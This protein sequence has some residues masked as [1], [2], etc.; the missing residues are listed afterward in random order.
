MKKAGILAGIL[1]AALL[2]A[3][4]AWA[5]K[6]VLIT[7]D[8]SVSMFTTNTLEK[9]DR[10]AEAFLSVGE[11]K[12]LA[13]MV[14]D[15]L[16]NGDPLLQDR[17][18]QMRKGLFVKPYMSTASQFPPPYWQAGDR[19]ILAAYDSALAVRADE[20][21]LQSPGQVRDIIMEHSP[22]PRGLDDSQ[23]IVLDPNSVV[24]QAFVRAFPGK[25]SLH[26]LA[27]AQAWKLYA[28]KR[29]EGEKLAQVIWISV[30]DE[31]HDTTRSQD[32]HIRSARAAEATANIQERF[33]G[34]YDHHT[35][36]RA[37]VGERIFLT[38]HSIGPRW[39]VLEREKMIMDLLEQRRLQ[40]E[41]LKTSANL[42]GHTQGVE[43]QLNALKQT[44]EE[45]R[46]RSQE[47][48]AEIQ[49]KLEEMNQEIRRLDLMGGRAALAEQM[50]ALKGKIELVRNEIEQKNNLPT[51]EIRLTRLE[52][53][54]KALADEVE[55]QSA[56][57]ENELGFIRGRI[58][59]LDG[60]AN[61]L[62]EENRRTE[63]APAYPENL[64]NIRIGQQVHEQKDI[65]LALN[66]AK[67]EPGGEQLFNRQIT[68]VPVA[69]TSRDFYFDSIF[70]EFLDNKGA[71]LPGITATVPENA[72]IVAG[73]PLVLSMPENENFD[74]AGK[75]RL[76]VEYFVTAPQIAGP[77][78]GRSQEW[79][80]DVKHQKPGLS[81]L[82][83]V[84]L[85][86]LAALALVLWLV[87]SQ[88]GRSAAEDDD[89]IIRDM[90][91]EGGFDEGKAA[92]AGVAGA[93]AAASQL[94]IT[95]KGRKEEYF[96]SEG[97]SLVFDQEDD[98][99]GGAIL[100]D[101]QCPGQRL[102]FKNSQLVLK[103]DSLGLP[104]TLELEQRDG[105]RIKLKIKKI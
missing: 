99:F 79:V 88:R 104:K 76:R 29:D 56:L 47:E 32:E 68:L 55:K 69:F 42:Q 70:M 15:L 46:T 96:L 43:E 75:A 8:I 82:L 28:D 25:A 51:F 49:N 65:A 50:E 23:K 24:T 35:L 38:V 45:D 92:L 62:R 7:Y 89:G 84:L 100:W 27:E 91:D 93:G 102:E 39:D 95:A 31:D 74:L 61:A 105:S 2:F 18:M 6:T 67:D 90:D 30:S 22:Y 9:P 78:S 34:T 4:P 60:E 72:D 81:V 64:L 44:M 11:F 17:Y 87:L 26:T 36:F 3:A 52:E 10:R 16:T 103:G 59:Y 14:A 98:T 57:S 37:F 73:S 77:D 40:I 101:L 85:I 33:R 83:V 1:M 86:F 19:L 48:L 94:C 66:F 54:I 21:N 97:Q 58:E 13:A 12:A 71:V 5:Q 41:E 80:F 63:A 53:Q 20:G